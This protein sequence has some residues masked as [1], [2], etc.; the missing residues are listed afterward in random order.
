[1][2][3]VCKSDESDDFSFGIEI[4]KSEKEIGSNNMSMV[5][6]SPTLNGVKLRKVINKEKFIK[7]NIDINGQPLDVLYQVSLFFDNLFRRPGQS[8]LPF[9]L[10]LT[11]QHNPS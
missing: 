6:L 5:N 7:L 10:A 8:S 2:L 9:L 3:P 4:S 11:F 1:M